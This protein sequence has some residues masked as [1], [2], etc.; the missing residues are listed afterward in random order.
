MTDKITSLDEHRSE[1]DQ[2]LSALRRGLAHPEEVEKWAQEHQRW[3]EACKIRDRP[4]GSM[5]GFI[6]IG[7]HRILTRVIIHEGAARATF[8]SYRPDLQDWKDVTGHLVIGPAQLATVVETKTSIDQAGEEIKS[9]LP[10]STWQTLD[11]FCAFRVLDFMEKNAISREDQI[12][13]RRAVQHATDVRAKVRA[14]FKTRYS[15][16]EEDTLIET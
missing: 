12:G 11:M 14:I 1:G 13:I 15:L 9:F 3:V 16:E 7:K 5:D 6:S 8:E 2:F 10:G 4:D